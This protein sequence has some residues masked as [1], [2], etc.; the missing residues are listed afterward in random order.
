MR[1]TNRTTFLFSFSILEVYRINFPTLNFTNSFYVRI[2]GTWFQ[3][4]SY[5]VSRVKGTKFR[6]GGTGAGTEY[7]VS[8]YPT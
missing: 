4:Y 2:Q 6:G 8:H 7:V 5:L 3:S 1:E